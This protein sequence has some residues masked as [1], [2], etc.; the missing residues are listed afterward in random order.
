MSPARDVA[1]WIG[2]DKLDKLD[3]LDRL[4]K[5]DRLDGSNFQNV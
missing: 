5:L 1:W 4:D 2:L 3:R